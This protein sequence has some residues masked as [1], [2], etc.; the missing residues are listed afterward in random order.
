VFNTVQIHYT[1]SPIFERGI[2]DPVPVRSGFVEGLF[3]DVVSLEILLKSVSTELFKVTTVDDAINDPF[4]GIEPKV[5][6]TLS[7]AIS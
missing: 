6:L 4:A 2:D 3:G 5:G 7:D 1:A